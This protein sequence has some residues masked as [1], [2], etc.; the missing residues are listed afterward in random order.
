MDAE[1]DA[2]QVSAR[3][4]ERRVN[5]EMTTRCHVLCAIYLNKTIEQI[6]EVT[7]SHVCTSFCTHTVVHAGT[8]W[9]DSTTWVIDR[10]D[11]SCRDTAASTRSPCLWRAPLDAA[12]TFTLELSLRKVKHRTGNYNNTSANAGN[13]VARGS[14]E[15]AFQ[16][17]D[18]AFDAKLARFKAV[19]V[20]LRLARNSHCGSLRV[21]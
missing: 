5:Y 3:A 11:S 16:Q 15:A 21:L 14:L 4:S 6:E 12:L 17:P 1:V 19:I 9:L 18:E 2:T 8:S 10:S 20:H 7:T 13:F